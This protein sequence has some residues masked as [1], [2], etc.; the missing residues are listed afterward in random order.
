MPDSL[1][2]RLRQDAASVERRERKAALVYATRVTRR[3]GPTATELIQLGLIADLEH[4][5]QKRLSPHH[6]R[7]LGMLGFQP[8]D[9]TNDKPAAVRAIR[10]LATREREA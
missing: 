7:A 4:G 1:T 8:D 10:E 9:F 2:T 6:Q 3:P 5:K